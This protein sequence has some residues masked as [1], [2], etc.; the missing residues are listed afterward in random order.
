MTLVL[1]STIQEYSWVGACVAVE[2]RSH[3]HIR[4]TLGKHQQSDARRCR[5]FWGASAICAL[6]AK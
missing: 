6:Y 4:F 1:F 2:M 3:S 5:T